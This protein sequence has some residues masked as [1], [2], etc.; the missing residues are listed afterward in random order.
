MVYNLRKELQEDADDNK[1]GDPM[2]FQQ[3][4]VNRN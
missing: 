4:K 3:R 1:S 2:K